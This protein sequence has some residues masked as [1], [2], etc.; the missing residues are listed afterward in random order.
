MSTLGKRKR[1]SSLPSSV[2]VPR[3]KAEVVDELVEDNPDHLCYACGTNW[4]K[5]KLKRHIIDHSSDPPRAGK[6]PVFVEVPKVRESNSLCHR[7]Y[8]GVQD[9][10]AESIKGP[11]TFESVTSG[12]REFIGDNSILKW[13]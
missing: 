3:G 5:R 9:Y 12:D 10:Y 2:D 7:C 11:S 1:S 4:K 8:G 6:F 13:C